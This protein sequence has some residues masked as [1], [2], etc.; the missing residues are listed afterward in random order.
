MRHQET[1][2]PYNPDQHHRRSIRLQNWDYTSAGAYFVTICVESR[3]CVFGEI[4]DGEMRLNALGN[5]V[6][7]YWQNLPQH[8]PNIGLD[9][10]VVMPNHVHFVVWL[11]PPDDARVGAQS[12]G[13]QSV[14]AQSVGA[15]SVGAQLNC[16]PTTTTPIEFPIG[17]RFTVDKQRP[18]LGQVVRVFKAATTRL[19]RQSGSDGFA[20]QRNY[21]EHIIRD[22]RELDR[23]RKYILD[24]PAN[25]AGDD[26]NP[27]KARAS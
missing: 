23:I 18:T 7:K 8:F 11:N 25:W 6:A 27:N 22:E 17:K 20:W 26:E 12:V 14:G 4:V 10:F 24:N 15:Q 19:I 1:N 9:A 13:A 5:I 2:M 16:A 3:E 21:Y